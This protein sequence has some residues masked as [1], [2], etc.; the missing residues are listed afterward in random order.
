[1][2]LTAKDILDKEFDKKFKGYDPQEVDVFLDEVIRDYDSVIKERDALL[3]E[4]EELTAKY[5]EVKNVKLTGDIKIVS[6]DT[7][8]YQAPK[9]ILAN[10][11]TPRKLGIPGESELAGKGIGTNAAIDGPSFSGKNIYVIGGADGAVKEAIYLAQFA[12]RLTIIHFEN[13]LG[14]IAEFKNKIKQLPNISVL[15]NSRLK[16]VYGTNQIEKIDILSENDSK[17]TTIEDE[18]CGIFIYA[19]STPNTELYKELSLSDGYIPVN[20]KMETS[21]NGVY[22]A[23]DICVKQVRQAATAV[24]DGAIAGINAAII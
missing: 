24:S 17:I 10:G 11:T 21:I 2:A 23:G 19:G 7:A 9:I 12:K 22:A 18:G 3:A 4:K 5:E 15:T 20:E 8:E 13:T 6:T 14:C 16:A 1:M